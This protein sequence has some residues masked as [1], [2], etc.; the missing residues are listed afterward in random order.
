MI[1]QLRK[2]RP[3]LVDRVVEHV[4]DNIMCGRYEPGSRITEE[5]L[6]A[7]VEVSR[8]PVREAVKRLSDLGL[9]IAKPRSGLMVTRVDEQDVR[10]VRAVRE[11]LE[12]LAVRLAVPRIEDS[13]IERLEAIQERCEELL[14]EEETDRLAVFRQDSRLHLTIAE[15]SGN[16]HLQDMLRRL[17]IQVMLCRMFLCRS[18]E[19]VGHDVEFHREII[20]ALSAGDAEKAESLIREHLHGAA[21][22]KENHTERAVPEE[23][24]A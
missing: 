3:T 15:I 13:D 11:E 8:T 16:N 21:A 22:L 7:E 10:D 5:Q 12:A 2:K 4:F 18:I 6:A 14:E 23:Q 17:D 1:A 9:I 24:T 20:A 19:K